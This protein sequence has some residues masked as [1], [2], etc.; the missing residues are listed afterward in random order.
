[1][2]NF[3]DGYNTGYVPKT[4]S[5]FRTEAR[6][7]LTGKWG[8]VIVCLILTGVV[9][10]LAGVLSG[11][12]PVIGF[13][14]PTI[15]SGVISFGLITIYLKASRNEL[16]STSDVFSGFNDFG[17]VFAASF[18][19]GLF[20]F[21]WSLLLIIPGIIAGLNYSLTYYILRDNP[22]ISASQAI[23]ESKRL[24]QGNKWRLFCLYFSFIGWSILCL[25]TFGIGLLWLIPYMS[26]SYTAFYNDIIGYNNFNNDYTPYFTN[27]NCLPDN[28]Q[29]YD[30]T[31]YDNNNFNNEYY[32]N[33]NEYSNTTYDESYNNNFDNS[34]FN[35][36]YENNNYDE[37]DNN[38]N[39]QYSDENNNNIYQ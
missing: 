25:F 24:M 21:L 6:Q 10:L 15:L 38:A 16:I 31:N 28:S 8:S 14:I 1:M 33:S 2:S 17:R 26:T 7:A 20:T 34:N 29:T 11:F 39:Y 27:E 13:F 19:T 37:F 36:N 3:N 23:S 22:N 9:T 4:A 18:L 35:G 12:I 30:N 5:D 32:N